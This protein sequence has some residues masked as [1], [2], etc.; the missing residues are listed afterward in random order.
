MVDVGASKAT[1]DDDGVNRATALRQDDAQF[2]TVIENKLLTLSGP[3]KR[4]I[5]IKLP[6]GMHYSTGDYLAM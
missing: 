3:Q 5:E 6:E 4:H 2:G 1:T